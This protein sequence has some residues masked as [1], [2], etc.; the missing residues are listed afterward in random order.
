MSPSILIIAGE[1]SGDNVGGLLAAE[2]VLLRPDIELIGIG[3]DRMDMAG[4]N[5]RYHVNQ[6]SFLGF[7]EVVKHLPFIREV[8]RNIL[9]AANAHRPALAILIDYPGFN[10]RLAEKLRALNVPIMYYVSPQ[11]WAW[12]KGRIAKIKRLV[13]KMVVVFEFEKCLYEREGM[14]VEWHGHPLLDI[15]HPKYNR[16][17]FSKKLGLQHDDAYIGLFPGSRR[18]EIEKILP[19]MQGALE[20][21]AADGMPVRGIVGCAPGIDD[22]SYRALGGHNLRYIRGNTYDLMTHAELNL[23]AS[24]TA[25]LECAMLNRPL[26]VLYK[27]SGLTYIIARQL[28]KIPF[29]GLVNV[30]AGEKVVPEFIQGDCKADIIAAEMKRYFN[31]R[32]LLGQMITRLSGVRSKLGNPGASEKVARTALGMLRND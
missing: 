11:V 25:T 22:R 4:V 17:D 13:D 6:L 14:T 28:V 32:A 21:L 1:A 24:G 12:G 5:L 18:Q 7:W 9:E 30:V 15:V 16:A 2:L 31:D 19:V 3:G 26:F 29:I 20:R 10:L 8:E 27:T 23:V